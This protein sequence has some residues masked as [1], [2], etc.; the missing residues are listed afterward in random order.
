[1]QTKIEELEETIK[2]LKS[3]HDEQAEPEQGEGGNEPETPTE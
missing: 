1:M 3:Y 2:D